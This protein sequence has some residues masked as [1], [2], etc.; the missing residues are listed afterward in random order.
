MK[1]YTYVF[2]FFH[3]SPYRSRSK[4]I[5]AKYETN[6]F[7]IVHVLVQMRQNSLYLSSFI[8]KSWLNDLEDMVQCEQSLVMIFTCCR[9]HTPQDVQGE[10]NPMQGG[11]YK[12][13]NPQLTNIMQTRYELTGKSV[14]HDSIRQGG[15]LLLIEYATVINEV[16]KSFK[17]K[18]QW[19][20]Q[21]RN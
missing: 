16:V 8:A 9:V 13:P 11:A 10:L 14:I 15:V 2:L 6:P 18:Y 19:H 4:V 20:E 17:Q 21:K 7:S 5:A 1:I 12:K 3:I